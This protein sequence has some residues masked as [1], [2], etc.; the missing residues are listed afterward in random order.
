LQLWCAK[1]KKNLFL[2]VL[3]KIISSSSSSSKAATRAT[4]YM[5]TSSKTHMSAQLDVNLKTHIQG[6]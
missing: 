6:K 1:K 4:H 2:R 3:K 5:I